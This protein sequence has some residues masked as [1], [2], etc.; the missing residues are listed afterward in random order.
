MC[1]APRERRDPRSRRRIKEHLHQRESECSLNPSTIRY[2]RLPQNGLEKEPQHSSKHYACFR[3][4]RATSRAV[5]RSTARFFKSARLSRA[6]LPNPTPSSAFTF[7][8]F[9]YN[10][11]TTRPGLLL[12]FRRRACRSPPGEVAIC[13]RVSR[14]ELRGWHAR[15]VGYRRCKE[16]LRRFQFGR[17]RR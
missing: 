5:S 8:L 16:T 14:L 17:T 6:T 11:R 1:I 3:L 7:A 13:G 2:E 15:T 9:Q 12:A 10:F 4:K